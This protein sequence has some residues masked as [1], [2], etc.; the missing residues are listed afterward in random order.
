MDETLYGDTS[1]TIGFGRAGVQTLSG[2]FLVGD[3]R[4][5]TGVALGA[6]DHLIAD[7]TD[8]TQL[9]GDA[10][11]M[12][13][14]ARGGNDLIEALPNATTNNLVGDAGT[15]LDATLGGND[16]IGGADGGL[17]MI[18]GDAI[19]ITGAS[20]GGNDLLR[21]GDAN[22]NQ[23]YGD[24]YE[25]RDV[26]RGGS[27][28]LVSGTGN[29]D[30]WGDARVNNSIA[31]GGRDVFVF[32]P[33]N[34]SDAIADFQRGEDKIDLHALEL[35]GF[36]DLQIDVEPEG[37]SFITLATGFVRVVGVTN[38]AASDFIF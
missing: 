37:N 10:I 5:L 4:E 34:G 3:A 28:T 7:S 19:T 11:V 30:M 2:R 15:M 1:G 9:N 24:A 18:Y 17:N 38:L 13:G 33:G 14:V 8:H 16:T 29:D 25:L 20:R 36:S 32:L 27:D 35:N 26:A 21:A 31:P 22:Y 23:L 12:S 6:G